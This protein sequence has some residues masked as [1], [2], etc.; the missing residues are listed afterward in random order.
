M[1]DNEGHWIALAHNGDQLAFWRLVNGES[2]ETIGATFSMNVSQC[3]QAIFRAVGKLRRA[4]EEW[5]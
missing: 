1:H 5:R 4:F 3:K 2:L